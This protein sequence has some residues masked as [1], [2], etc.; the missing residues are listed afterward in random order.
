[1]QELTM[2]EVMEVSGGKVGASHQNPYPVV[3]HYK[4]YPEL[5]VGPGTA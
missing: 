2:D 5:Q 4:L 3:S 1:M